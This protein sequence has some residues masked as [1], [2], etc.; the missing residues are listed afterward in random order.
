[1][2]EVCILFALIYNTDRNLLFATYKKSGRQWFRTG[3][4]LFE[5]EEKSILD[6]KPITHHI[7]LKLPRA[8]SLLANLLYMRF[9]Y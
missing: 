7:K 8:C 6:Q 9:Y 5:A 4:I 3:F 2:F 1:M